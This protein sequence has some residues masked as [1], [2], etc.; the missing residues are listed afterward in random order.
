MNYYV[1]PG[2]CPAEVYRIMKCADF[3]FLP[4]QK[5]AIP[6]LAS[7]SILG[8]Y[9]EEAS[10]V[11][12]FLLFDGCFVDVVISPEHQR[13]WARKGLC[14]EVLSWLRGKA[15]GGKLHF[16][17]TSKAAQRMALAVGAEVSGTHNGLP[18]YILK[19]KE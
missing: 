3:P 9:T 5:E 11:G 12:A 13:R 4:A 1:K 2:A 10:L 17:T 15:N 16:C 14:A 7:A 6:R 19:T 8:L 18:Y